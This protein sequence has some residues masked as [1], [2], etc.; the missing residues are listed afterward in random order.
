V[1]AHVT[2]GVIGKCSPGPCKV[3]S[4]E[5]L[6]EA[7]LTARL[8]GEEARELWLRSQGGLVR[9]WFRANP[10]CTSTGCILEPFLFPK[11]AL[12]VLHFQVK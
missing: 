4:P 2:F 5:E 6:G 8:E 7:S 9:T 11:D 12:E 1:K 10:P 3:S